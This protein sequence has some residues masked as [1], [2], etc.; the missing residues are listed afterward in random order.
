[1]R[2]A[3]RAEVVA[4]VELAGKATHLHCDQHERSGRYELMPFLIAD[5]EDFTAGVMSYVP[6]SH[7][8]RINHP[9]TPA[10]VGGENGREGVAIMVGA[11]HW[12]SQIYAVRA[13]RRTW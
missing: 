10:P 2:P 6:T 5:R 8:P 4:A 11:N 3:T 9:G 7:P 12:H 13:T 1:M